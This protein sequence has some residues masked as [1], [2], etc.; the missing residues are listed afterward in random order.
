MKVVRAVM[1]CLLAVCAA[2]DTLTTCNYDN[3][4]KFAY[5]FE[6]DAIKCL[7]DECAQLRESTVVAQSCGMCTNGNIT[8]LACDKFV[9]TPR[10]TQKMSVTWVN[11]VC[12]ITGNIRQCVAHVTLASTS[13]FFVA[14]LIVFLLLCA[15]VAPL[16]MLAAIM[17]SGYGSSDVTVVDGSSNKEE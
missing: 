7:G 5:Q 15:F 14:V 9:V 17:L 13:L 4:Q 2:A 16:E 8:C 12:D 3:I 1:V 11:C 10:L 6:D